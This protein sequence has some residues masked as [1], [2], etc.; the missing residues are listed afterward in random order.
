MKKR[1]LKIY[2]GAAILFAGGVFLFFFL[3]EFNAPIADRADSNDILSH[4]LKHLENYQFDP[5]TSLSARV[6]PI[7]EMVLSAWKMWDNRDDYVPHMPSRKEMNIIAQILAALPPLNTQV[8]KNRL[9]GIY[10]VENFATGGLT[11]WVVDKDNNIYVYIIINTTALQ[12]E[13]SE[14]LTWKEKSCFINDDPSFDIEID[15]NSSQRGFLYIILHESCHA[16]D[17]ITGMTPFVEPEMKRFGKI[18]D[19]TDFTRGI[20][21]SY[22][23]SAIDYKFRENVI[24]YQTPRINISQ[25][26]EVYREMDASPFISLYGSLNWAEDLSEFLTFYHLT[27]KMGFNYQIR[28]SR[29]G[30]SLYSLEPAKSEAKRGRFGN[31]DT[32]YRPRSDL[33]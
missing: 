14:F 32:F 1:L 20:W 25:A 22:N 5:E 16:V 11:D 6:Q 4:P 27:E 8:M 9:I 10:F 7:P 18:P 17:F 2:I 13:M 21:R 31:M 30:K 15:V 26:Q 19:D 33:K 29:N 28:V 3:V 12:M 24:F 23:E